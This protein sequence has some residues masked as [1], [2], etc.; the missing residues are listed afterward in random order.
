MKILIRVIP[1]IAIGSMAYTPFERH[2]WLHY[3]PRFERLIP[4]NPQMI[5]E[6][7]A[8]NIPEAMK[9]IFAIIASLFLEQ[10]AYWMPFEP[11]FVFA[12]LS[13]FIQP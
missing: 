11:E 10:S 13:V 4:F 5:F 1:N 12:L 6:G 9:G 7:R 3:P 8:S 2:L